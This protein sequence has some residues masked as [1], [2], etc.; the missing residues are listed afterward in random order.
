MTC[1]LFAIDSRLVGS[2]W[3]GVGSLC[4]L[5]QLWEH[6][7][8]CCSPLLSRAS[9]LQVAFRSKASLSAAADAGPQ[10]N[11]YQPCVS[12]LLLCA[13][14]ASNLALRRLTGSGA[15]I[16]RTVV[17][18]PPYTPPDLGNIGCMSHCE[19]P[20]RRPEHS[21][22]HRHCFSGPAVHRT[23]PHQS[24]HPRGTLRALKVLPHPHHPHQLP[25][26]SRK[27]QMPQKVVWA[28]ALSTPAHVTKRCTHLVA[29]EDQC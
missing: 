12:S 19:L 28:P 10:P 1:L 7:H 29:H 6:R 25:V 24:Q 15:A 2:A 5:A 26:R 20:G 14:P 8:A 21:A 23:P 9:G 11:T 27:A 22:E 13:S 18:L 16:C 4:W 3:V 17:P